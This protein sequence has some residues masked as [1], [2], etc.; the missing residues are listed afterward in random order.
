MLPTMPSAG[1]CCWTAAVKVVPVDVA[2]TAQYNGTTFTAA[3]QQ[4]RPAL[5]IVGNIL[6]VGYGSMGDCGLFHGWLVGVPINN[7]ASVTAWAAGAI[8]DVSIW[9]GAIW[10]V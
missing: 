10:G 9:G 6:Y 3:V 8:G 7:P 5:G 2:L 4:Q 1:R